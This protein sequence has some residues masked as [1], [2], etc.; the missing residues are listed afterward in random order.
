MK[1]NLKEDRA[2]KFLLQY[3]SLGAVD[4]FKTKTKN[5]VYGYHYAKKTF[6][7]NQFYMRKADSCKSRLT[8]V[9]L[10]WRVGGTERQVDDWPQDQED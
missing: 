3:T 10:S 9:P 2:N 4:S 6:W 1:I 7:K 8:G 5:S